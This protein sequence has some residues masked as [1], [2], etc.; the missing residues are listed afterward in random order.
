M[1]VYSDHAKYATK[2]LLNLFLTCILGELSMPK[3]NLQFDLGFMI[4]ASSGMQNYE[5]SVKSFISSI[6]SKFQIAQNSAHVA[7]TMASDRTEKLI[8]FSDGT[9]N[10]HF[11]SLRD[12]LYS[13][14]RLLFPL[15]SF[16]LH[17]Y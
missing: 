2:Y 9:G 4:D 6:L 12:P 10:D 13:L 5:K 17:N 15:L 3:Q 8:G 7:V 14:S 16:S 11:I 1:I